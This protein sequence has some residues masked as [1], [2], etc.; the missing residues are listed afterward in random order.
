MPKAGSYN[1]RRCEFCNK[2]CFTPCETQKNASK[3]KNNPNRIKPIN[4][5]L[6]ESTSS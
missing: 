3:C 4:R 6:D 1:C 5:K 2:K